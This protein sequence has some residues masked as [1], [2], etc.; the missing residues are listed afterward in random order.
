MRLLVLVALASGIARAEP[1]PTSLVERPL[2]LPR[3]MIQPTLEGNLSN[4]LRYYDPDLNHLG[5]S[6]GFGVDIGISSRIQ[7]GFF[8][9][10]PLSPI[11]N[12]GQVVANLQAS[13]VRNLFNLRV[14]LGVQRLS[15]RSPFGNNHSDWLVLGIGLP[16]RLKLHSMVALVAGSTT[17]RGFGTPPFLAPQ[18]DDWVNWSGA[19]ASNDVLALF[20]TSSLV[21][22]SVLVPFGLLIQPHP[23]VSFGGRAG[24]RY[25]FFR[26]SS[27]PTLHYHFVPV[28]FDL[29]ITVGQSVD[30]G[31]TATIL[32]PVSNDQ[33][34]LPPGVYFLIPPTSYWREF[35]S[36]DFFVAAR[37]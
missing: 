33:R 8:F 31:F 6:L 14:D 18:G 10:L 36:Y 17:A 35:Q 24:Y 9:T 19:F 29:T 28:A 26:S 20:A 11:A 32:G 27:G 13:L 30:L 4:S 15:Q 22:G 25:A 5:G 2:T 34:S 37:F 12:L 23:I 16:L 1:L 21:N 7:A 3:A